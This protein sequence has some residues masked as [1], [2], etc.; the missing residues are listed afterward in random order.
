[1][2]TFS[3]ELNP[4]EMDDA[5]WE[6]FNNLMA[7]IQDG[8]VKYQ[9]EIAEELNISEACAEYVQYLR[10]R[11]RWTQEKEDQPIKMDQAGETLP[12]VLAGDF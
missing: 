2:D 7:E 9:H 8:M 4:A 6:R 10:T 1:M 3:I 12:N 5:G 11:S